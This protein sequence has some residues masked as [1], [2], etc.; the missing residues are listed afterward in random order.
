MCRADSNLSFVR[1]FG[2]PS[3]YE[4]SW[5]GCSGCDMICIDNPRTISILSSYLPRQTPA[6]SRGSRK[7]LRVSENTVL[8]VC[9]G[10]FGHYGD[11]LGLGWNSAGPWHF[12]LTSSTCR[13][14]VLSELGDVVVV[15]ARFSSM[16]PAL[17]TWRKFSI[18]SD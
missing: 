13:R 18:G 5:R 16:L 1:E 11:R 7:L 12:W 3:N 10:S 2:F 8:N 6:T 14:L 9:F 15:A 4:P 17:G